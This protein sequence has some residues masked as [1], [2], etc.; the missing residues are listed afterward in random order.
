MNKA[1]RLISL[2]VA[3][4][5]LG[6]LPLHANA[7]IEHFGD[8]T[9]Y[10]SVVNSTF[11]SP[12]IAAQYGITRGERVAFLNISVQKKDEGLGKPVHATLSGFRKNLL[13]Q[14]ATIEFQEIQ[15]GAAIY[16]I[17]E[18]GFSNAELV[19]FEVEIQPED[20]V[21]SYTLKWDGRVYINN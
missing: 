3:L 10:Y 2:P 17:G 16:Y 4:L 14:T 6:L 21:L 8:Y 11:I 1:T 15:E 19:T 9:V 20:S 18:F 7:Q 5:L 13:Q 12:E